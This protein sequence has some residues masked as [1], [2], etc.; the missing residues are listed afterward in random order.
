MK[1]QTEI[2]NIVAPIIYQEFLKVLD[3]AKKP[4]EFKGSGIFTEVEECFIRSGLSRLYRQRQLLFGGVEERELAQKLKQLAEGPLKDV[5]AVFELAERYRQVSGGFGG[6]YTLLPLRDI[7]RDKL[8]IK[9][10]QAQGDKDLI[11]YCEVAMRGHPKVVS[12]FRINC[13]FVLVREDG[14]RQRMVTLENRNGEKSDLVSLGA[15]PF[16]APRDFREWLANQGNFTWKEGERELEKLQSDI[17]SEAAFLEVVEVTSLGDHEPSGI[18]FFGDVAF[19]PADEE[20]LPDEHR[21]IWVTDRGYLVAPL[22]SDR[23]D[24]RQP[25]PC[26]RPGEELAFG[27]SYHL[28]KSSVKDDSA[29]QVLFQD[30]SFRLRETLGGYEGYMA[31]G[32]LLAFSA[33]RDIFRR[34]GAFPGLWV[35]GEKGS[36][37]STL[38]QLLM[39]LQGFHMLSG[40]G[41]PRNCSV[42]GLQIAVEQFANLPVWLDE[43]REA[44]VHADKRAI[45]HAAFNRELPSKFSETGRMRRIRTAFIVAGESTTTDAATRSRYAHIHVNKSRR[46]GDHLPWLEKHR[47][48]FFCLG[49]FSLRN[50]SQ[51]SKLCLK[52]LEQWLESADLKSIEERSRLVYGIPYA[53]F[54]TMAEMLKSHSGDD[55]QKFRMD[56]VAQA[57]VATDEVQSQTDVSQFFEYVYAAFNN[58]AFGKSASE[59]KHFFNTER[60]EAPH[61]PNA[62]DQNQ[63]TCFSA[64]LFFKPAPV[65]DVVRRYLR[66]Q[67]LELKL[68]QLDLRRQMAGKKYWLNPKHGMHRKNFGGKNNE[69]CWGIDLSHHPLGLQEVNLEDWLTHLKKVGLSAEGFFSISEDWED[70]RHGELFAIVHKLLAK[71]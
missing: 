20:F 61:P 41:L 50:R 55:L 27:E 70:P 32:A 53:A 39:E 56:L 26:M 13:H 49:R 59:L 28:V 60:T 37:K 8:T 7:D 66:F 15:R 34:Y 44:E 65:I 5:P 67:G 31:I 45:I 21:V 62:P 1:T 42:A 23:Q 54:V 6:Y 2:W 38:V 43:F 17:N 47:H 52:H 29:I 33:A 46:Q 57:R 4:G 14:T 69:G 24:F 11:W 30:L 35:T 12:D 40:L 63:V 3:S 9:R 64:N 68:N 22:G 10:D 18:T 71:E 16:T 58:G 48:L 36:G 19:G 51:F 25:L